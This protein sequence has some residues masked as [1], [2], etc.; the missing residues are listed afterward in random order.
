M[1]LIRMPRERLKP[2]LQMCTEEPLPMRLVAQMLPP[3]AS[4]AR[5][6]E[7]LNCPSWTVAHPGRLGR[8]GKSRALPGGAY[9]A[10]RLETGATVRDAI[11]IKKSQGSEF[12]AVVTPLARQRNCLTEHLWFRLSQTH[13]N[14]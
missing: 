1:A 10:N 14:A 5:A 7:R 11:T 4:G 2:K 13:R 8:D 12:P 6:A 3:I 9:G